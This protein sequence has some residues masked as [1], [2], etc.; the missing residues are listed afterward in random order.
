[1]NA[2]LL[3]NG[4]LVV[5]G[6]HSVQAAVA[7]RTV[8]EAAQA[9]ALRA[10][11]AIQADYAALVIS[12]N[13]AVS[14]VEA[15]RDE[16]LA[17]LELATA[18]RDLAIEERDAAIVERDEALARAFPL[19]EFI[20][21]A[22]PTGVNGEGLNSYIDDPD[23]VLSEGQFALLTVVAKNTGLGT[24]KAFI[25]LRDSHIAGS[26]TSGTITVGGVNY[27][28]DTRTVTGVDKGNLVKFSPIA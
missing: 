14:D 7:A 3:L 2:G 12:A 10:L 26:G 13:A 21:V 8:A 27:D 18:A 25:Q 5:A 23:M 15:Q 24:T 22:L 16:A 1:M 4:A 11:A 9:E 19:Y 6:Y 20:E 17:D 28:Y